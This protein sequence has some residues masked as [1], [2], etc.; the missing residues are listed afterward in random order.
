MVVG[1]CERA[2]RTRARRYCKLSQSLLGGALLALASCQ[3]A[4]IESETPPQRVAQASFELS[5][6][7]C[8]ESKDTGY[9]SGK[10]FSITVVTV[11]G[12]KV[13]R[14]TA[15]AYYVMAQAAAKAGVNLKVVSGFRTNAEQTYLYNCYKNCNCNNCNLA[16]KPGYSNHQSG[17]AL[18]LNAS[19]SGVYNWLSANGAKFG[20]KRTV[21]SENWHWEWWGGGPGGGP[22]GK[23]PLCPASGKTTICIDKSK[24]GTCD[25]GHL[26]TGD[27]GAFG[28]YCSTAGVTKARCVSVFCVKDEKAVPKAHDVCIPDNKA[29]HCDNAG[30]LT[31][32]VTCSKSE[33]CAVED[34]LAVCVDPSKVPADSGAS[35][36]STDDG[37]A[38]APDFDQTPAPD[39]GFGVGS[40]S[41]SSVGVGAG[42]DA[43]PGG[44]NGASL[45]G[46]GCQVAGAELSAQPLLLG[47]L[48]AALL[49]LGRRRRRH[50]HAPSL[51][52]R[53]ASCRAR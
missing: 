9:T 31:S 33:K 14:D 8:S 5:S 17:H 12:K 39:N 18:D 20:F 10:S 37:G 1:F 25:N 50:H 28:A 19:A 34:G 4:D 6:I 42:E 53:D 43:G 38:L 51:R 27:C 40:D 21:P 32:V 16:A 15:N 7:S 44:A 41:G 49:T 26:S 36:D 48:L 22:C 3:G 23:S 30:A 24:I 29:A 52:R 47:L 46:S 2:R 35:A 13:E 45:Q 11:D